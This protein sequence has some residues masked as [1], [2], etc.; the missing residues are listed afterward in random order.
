MSLEA[1]WVEQA[2]EPLK[3][4]NPPLVRAVSEWRDRAE[5]A[6]AKLAELRA[7][8]EH[9]FRWGST[10]RGAMRRILEMGPT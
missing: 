10:F 2:K 4:A 3:A 8:A 6:E 1:H 5:K 9:D 7:L